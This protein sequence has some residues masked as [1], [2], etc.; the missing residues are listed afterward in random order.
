MCHY[1]LA[2]LQSPIDRWTVVPAVTRLSAIGVWPI[3]FPLSELS[4]TVTVNGC[5]CSPSASSV[6]V[7]DSWVWPLT[8]GTRIRMLQV[9]D[10]AA[11]NDGLELSVMATVKIGRAHV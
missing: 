2:P 4:L 3:T 10:V 8:S 9:Y 11:V 1:R 6:D 7:A 5:T